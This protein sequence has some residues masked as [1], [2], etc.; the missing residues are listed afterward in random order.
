MRFHDD[1][2]IRGEL[3]FS[4][5]TGEFDFDGMPSLKTHHIAYEVCLSFRPV[6]HTFILRTLI[7]IP[8]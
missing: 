6:A 5:L 1:L 8:R 3:A 4:V 7:M 2:Y